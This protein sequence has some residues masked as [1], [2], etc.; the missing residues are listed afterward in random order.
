MK[1]KHLLILMVLALLSLPVVAQEGGVKGRVVSRDDRTALSNVKVSIE[2]LDRSVITDAEGNF[3]FEG[4]TSGQY[5]LRFEAPEFEQYD[6][7]VRVD[8]MVKDIAAVSLL[9]D[10]Q[11]VM[12]D[13]I[14][15]EF[16]TDTETAGD[17][18]AL[19]SSLSSSKDVF[20]NIAS[21]KFSEMRL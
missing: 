9:P 12:D 13:A 5:K 21:Y 20:N 2:G 14:F 11:A 8:R 1:F 7:V 18:Q 19:P 10:V 6:L 17:S 15:A 3:H 4:L 16:D